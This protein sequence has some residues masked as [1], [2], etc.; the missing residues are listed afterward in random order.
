MKDKQNSEMFWGQYISTSTDTTNLSTYV[1]KDKK[2][3]E[4][5]ERPKFKLVLDKHSFLDH[6]DLIEWDF[7][8]HLYLITL[9]QEKLK[10]K[11]TDT[12]PMFYT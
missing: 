4:Y 10:F 7:G 1:S 5:F 3:G 6:W 12:G 2:S 9:S 11:D 8:S